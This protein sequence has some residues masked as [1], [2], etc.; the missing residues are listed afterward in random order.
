VK[1][2]GLANNHSFDLGRSG[3]EQTRAVLER[4]GIKPL[5]HK[6]VVDIGPFRLIGLNFIGKADYHDYP[7]VKDGDLDALC[8]M[9]ARPPLVALV[10]WGTEYTGTAGMSEYAAA[11]A[12]QA[13]GVAAIVGAHSHQAAPRIEAPQ[14]GEYQ[15]TYSLGNLLFDQ[16]SE[17]SSGA[18]LELRTFGQGTYAA[19]LIPIA[20]LFELATAE[21]QKKQGRSVTTPG[22]TSERS[23]ED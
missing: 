20:N 10:H 1:V 14:G 21:L 12:M 11:D 13:C 3:Y 19:R 23:R 2:A 9:K 15:M 18:L 6:D 16:K 5:G 4:A 8:R 22:T 17:R 7:V